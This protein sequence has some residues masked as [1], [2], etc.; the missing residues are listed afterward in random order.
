MLTRR[1]FIRITAATTAGALLP[2]AH[3]QT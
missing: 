2:L 1:R 3:A